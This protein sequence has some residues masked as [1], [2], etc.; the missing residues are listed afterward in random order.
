MYAR[1]VQQ[2]AEF[3]RE[4]AL[5]NFHWETPP[6]EDHFS[7]NFD[8]NKGPIHSTWFQGGRTN[9]C[10]NALDRHVLAG[11]GDQICFLFEGND[12]AN[13][14]E[15][16]YKQ[17]LDETCRVANWLLSQ[18]VKKGDAVAIYMPMVSELPIAMLACARIGA[19]HSVV[20][21]GFSAEALADRIQDCESRVII[22]ASGVMRA[23]KKIDL[24]S[25][26]D[27]ACKTCASRGFQVESAL[28]Y[29]NHDAGSRDSMVLVSGRDV[30]W[31]DVIPTQSSDAAVQ[32]VD[33][34]HPL[35]LLYTSGS[36]GKPKGVVHS[37]GGFMVYTA[38]TAKYSFAMQAGDRFW[39]TA[40]C[41]WITG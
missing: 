9:I 3:W 35:F 2:P 22:T 1:S 11:H 17:V 37:T 20:F 33:A 12:P 24:K 14:G 15:M 19:V 31:Q 21:G 38:T 4:I 18:G 8:M 34:E 30:V 16:T 36:T 25:I 27:A 39:C 29:H 13:H 23:T 10:Y 32:W 5:E 40:D 41:G 26:A 28:V 7:Y 6:A